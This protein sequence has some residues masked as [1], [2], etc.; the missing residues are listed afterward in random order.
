VTNLCRCVGLECG[1]RPIQAPKLDWLDLDLRFRRGKCFPTPYLPSL[2]QSTWSK[3][4]NADIAQP[5]FKIQTSLKAQCFNSSLHSFSSHS[6]F[7]LSAFLEP[8]PSSILHIFGLADLLAWSSDFRSVACFAIT[9]ATT[10]P[11][12]TTTTWRR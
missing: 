6:F 11:F 12:E 4:S 7:L 10:R 3:I 9:A 8:L 1:R 2:P 5:I